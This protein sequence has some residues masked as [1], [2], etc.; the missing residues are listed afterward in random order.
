MTHNPKPWL[1]IIQLEYNN[2]EHLC[3]IWRC[4]NADTEV[5]L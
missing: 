5:Y 2:T 3:V 4:I 1:I